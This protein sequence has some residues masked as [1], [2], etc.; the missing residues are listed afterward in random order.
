M[1]KK[2]TE[3]KIKSRHTI[4]MMAVMLLL[5]FVFSQALPAL[6]VP[7][8]RKRVNDNAGILSPSQETTLE[9][10]LIDTEQRTSSQVVLLT[11]SSLQGES[12]E[13]YSLR[14][15]EENKI[16]QE[17]FDNGVLLLV[18]MAERKIRI[19]TGYGLESIITDLKSGY[20]IRKLITPQFKKGLYYN[21]ISSGLEAVTGLITKDFQIT[22]EQL[23]RFQK[24][25]RRGK[26]RHLPMGFIVF[27][28]LI[29]ISSI[30]NRTRPGYRRGSSMIFWGGGF[31]GGSS[32]GGGGGGFGGFSGGGGGFGGGGSSGSW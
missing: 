29:V 6:E 21:G 20:I 9:N 7:R 3:T 17:E 22:P 13:E 31:G 2:I 27:I 5:L 25:Q 16:G 18:A 26:G 12:L 11:I 23:K 30:K 8:L 10:L 32:G 14:V 1:T 19:E 24:E 4:H 28:I 15:A